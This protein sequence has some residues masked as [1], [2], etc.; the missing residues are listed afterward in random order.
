[1]RICLISVEIFAWGKHGGF[2][3]A[4]RVLGR[5]LAA[6][7][8]DV[9]AIVPRRQDQ[10]EVEQLDGITVL[11]F[12]PINP[13][14]AA[15]LARHTDAEIYHS[16]EP[17]LTSYV[18]MR[19][20]PDRRHMVT[21]RDPRNAQDWLMELARPSLNYL[22]VMQNY[23]FENNVLV[24]RCIK[25][26]DAVY[27]SAKCLGPKVQAIYGL[28]TPADF[29]PTPIPIP[30]HVQKTRH[31][32]VCYVARLDR[33]KRPEL[34]LNLAEKFPEVEFLVAGKSRQ[35]SWEA[36]LHRRYGHLA[37]VKML[38]FV[39][40]FISDLHSQILSKSWILVNTA[41][42]EGLPNSMLEA[43]AHGCAI[44]SH[45]DPDG[46]ASNFG[47]HAAN[48]DFEKGLKWLLDDNRWRERGKAGR[49]YTF[50][51]F[52]L[53]RALDLHEAAYR[54]I[55]ARDPRAY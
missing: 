18:A 33:R 44:L 31:P 22:Q 52:E 8:H 10:G 2:G 14:S 41:T 30:T 1:M 4:T 47:Y 19:A 50:A 25:R 51:T 32:T 40:Q 48:D 43:A 39:D 37:N 45:V 9:F 24:R 53:N 34:F 36:S 12:P 15:R 29:L 38:G 16:C 3:R 27:T 6:R 17:S 35:R 21:S 42:R 49:A 55:L 13:W 5:E 26:M 23:L 28:P 7:G 20:M 54:H 11:S 46:F